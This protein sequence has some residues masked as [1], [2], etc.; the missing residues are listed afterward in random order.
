[1]FGDILAANHTVKAMQ[2]SLVFQNLI[3][4]AT[5]FVE[6]ITGSKTAFV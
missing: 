1:M 6:T 5:Y 3:Y 2:K 4:P